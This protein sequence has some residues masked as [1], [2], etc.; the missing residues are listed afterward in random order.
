MSLQYLDSVVI[1]AASDGAT[2]VYSGACDYQ[3]NDTRHGVNAQ[4]LLIDRGDGRCY[5]PDATFL[6]AESPRPTPG[7]AVAITIRGGG[8]TQNG[9]VGNVDFHDD[10]F[11][12]NHNGA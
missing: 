4:G 7:D 11:T 2:T 3:Y 5:V 9:A 1:T 6:R 12:V 8:G 10:S